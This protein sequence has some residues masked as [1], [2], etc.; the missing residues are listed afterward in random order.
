MKLYVGMA[1]S[2]LDHLATMLCIKR[3]AISFVVIL[4]LH[5]AWFA[6]I[7]F[8]SEPVLFVERTVAP[9]NVRSA[10]TAT[11]TAL[12]YIDYDSDPR[13]RQR[14]RVSVRQNRD[15]VVVTMI[16]YGCQDD[17]LGVMCDRLTMIG[18]DA[19]WQIVRHQQAWQGRGRIGWT[20]R[21]TL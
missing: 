10:R 14:L 17:S 12:A 16:E 20:T 8:R 13:A 4:A 19:R 21:P 18:S 5:M 3:M 6:W 1:K 9:G 2:R 15:T 11:E 7:H